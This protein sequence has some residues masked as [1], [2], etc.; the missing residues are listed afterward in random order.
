MA[1]INYE[2]VPF[3]ISDVYAALCRVLHMDN[4][5]CPVSMFANYQV[6]K[7]DNSKTYGMKGWG[8]NQD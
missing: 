6:A 4:Q 8:D 1:N 5:R 3:Q 7:F 2:Y